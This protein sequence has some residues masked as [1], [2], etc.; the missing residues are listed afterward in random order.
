MTMT[1]TI[2]TN[3]MN[4]NIQ[5]TPYLLASQAVSQPGTHIPDSANLTFHS[6][7]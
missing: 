2:V 1:M 3:W 5:A 7:S 4:V 6:H